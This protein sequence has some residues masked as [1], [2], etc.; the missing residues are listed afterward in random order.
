MSTWTS[1]EKTH[2]VDGGI[3]TKKQPR[4]NDSLFSPL[5]VATRTCART[6]RVL[7]VVAYLK[8]RK[9]MTIRQ[10]A[11]WEENTMVTLVRMNTMLQ[12]REE[13]NLAW[14]KTSWTGWDM[15]IYLRVSSL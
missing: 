7:N 6:S 14:I 12:D 1:R 11:G 9:I 2:S 10:L 13:K 4:Y 8:S 3:T 15:R 5:N